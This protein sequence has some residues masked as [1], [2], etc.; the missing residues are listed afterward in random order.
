M[1]V[2]VKSPYQ[3]VQIRGT[4]MRGGQMLY[5]KFK[6]ISLKANQMFDLIN[7]IPTIDANHP[8]VML[9]SSC[10]FQHDKERQ[11]STCAEC[12]PYSYMVKRM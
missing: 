11:V 1:Y 6:G 5:S 2:Y 7:L 3:C 4:F 9:A 12:H 10:Q 8:D